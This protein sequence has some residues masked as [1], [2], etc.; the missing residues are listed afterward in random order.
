MADGRKLSIASSERMV[1]Q[2]IFFR[3]STIR[4]SLQTRRYF[5]VYFSG[6]DRRAVLLFT[7]REVEEPTHH[8]CMTVLS[9]ISERAL[10]VYT[11]AGMQMLQ[12]A[13]SHTAITD[14]T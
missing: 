3:E 9:K 12:G 8:K 6:K 7:S 13:L 10:V 2:T 4:L 11:A 14:W 5:V 1:V